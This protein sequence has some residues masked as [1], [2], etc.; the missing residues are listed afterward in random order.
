ML[1]S[2]GDVKPLRIAQIYKRRGTHDIS[3]QG[4]K[5][6]LAFYVVSHV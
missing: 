2:S 4:R 3:L 1:L 6:N 5:L